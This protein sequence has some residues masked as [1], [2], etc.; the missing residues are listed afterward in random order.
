LQGNGYIVSWC[1][2]HLVELAAADAYGEPLKRWALDTLPILPKQWQ[3]KSSKDKAKQIA[4]VRR[5]M[6]RADVESVVCATDAGREGELIF[7]LIYDYC[8]CTKPIQRLWISSLE[9]SAIRDGFANLRPGADFEN[10]YRAALC[11][12]QADWL[13]GIN[14]T[15]L[16]SCL[17]RGATLNVGRVQTPTL[18][19]IVEREKA[20]AAFVSETFYTPQIDCDGFIAVGE[21]FGDFE[22]AEAVRVAAD[23]AD[24]VFV[25]VE[26][27]KKTA[28]PPKLYDLTSLQRDANKIFGFTAQQTLD[29][30]QSLYEAKRV[31]YPRTDS[32]FLTEDMAD[33]ASAVINS[34]AGI[35][36][37]AH[38]F[39]FV[40]DISKVINNSKVSDHHA[41]IPTLE[42]A[43]TDISALSMG[44][45]SILMLV[46][47]RLLCAVAPVHKF[48]TATAIL[49]CG[50]H[51]FT[52]KGKTVL[53]DGWRA[54]D[55]AFRTSLKNKPDKNED[56][57]DCG[58]LPKLAEGQVFSDVTASIREGKTAPPAR[59][60]EGTLLRAM[61]LA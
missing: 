54:I 51:E 53:D 38:A 23:G 7:R 8:N 41:I 19:M 10:L 3:Y 11:R 40:P 12:S 13:V 21:R 27:T 35:F 60:T 58:A 17:Y 50:G 18:A 37:F 30:T 16:F 15:R 29:Y 1:F 42:T 36:P 45:R 55:A 56:G 14:G 61:E 44:E 28:S 39:S 26:K 9:D 49:E 57:E 2:G 46:A 32:Q 6:N 34:L 47:A 22:A 5:L 20:I 48:E 59:F 33:T 4:F 24:A 43:K 25:S 31:T 52:A